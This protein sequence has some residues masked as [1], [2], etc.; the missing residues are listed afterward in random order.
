MKLRVFVG[1]LLLAVMLPLALPVNAQ[2]G[3]L[4][5]E[6]EA[7]VQSVQ[8][9]FDALFTV[10]SFQGRTESLITQFITTDAGGQSLEIDQNIEQIADLQITAAAGEISESYSRMTQNTSMT[11]NLPGLDQDIAMVLESVSTGGEMYLRLEDGPPEMSTIFPSGWT[12]ITDLAV[13]GL[14]TGAFGNLTGREALS[15]YDVGADI[16]TSVE[17]LDSATI[18]GQEMQVISLTFDADTLFEVTG[19]GAMFDPASMA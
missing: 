6:D 14:D 7:L 8:D 2:G 13:P 4:S 5:A 17:E 12:A 9:A 19:L 15:I 3:D 16:V 10:D 11:G 1:L 18:D